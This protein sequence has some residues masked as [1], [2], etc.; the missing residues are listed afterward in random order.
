MKQIYM[1]LAV[2]FCAS[3][4]SKAQNN[5]DDANF[6]DS[7]KYSIF[8]GLNYS[9][10]ENYGNDG[11]KGERSG[12]NAGALAEMPFANK[13][14]FEASL[15]FSVVGEQP[16]IDD[17][18]VARFRTYTINLPVQFKFYPGKNKSLSF[19]IGPQLSYNFEPKI[20][21]NQNQDFRTLEDVVNTGFDGT[22][23]FGYKLPGFGLF[24]KGTFSYGFADIFVNQ[25]IYTSE[26][27]KVIRIDIGYQF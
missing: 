7:I 18:V 6:D 24:I 21:E 11:F 13:W 2:L 20:F 25:D 10:L 9:F 23:G 17:R 3:Q 16:I 19:H 26:R 5:I 22:A 27:F 8:Y 4:F 1:C 12:Y 14:S 15:F